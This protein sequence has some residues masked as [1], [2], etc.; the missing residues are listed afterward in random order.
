MSYSLSDDTHD[1]INSVV[2]E[3]MGGDGDISPDEESYEDV[4]SPRTIKQ[5]IEYESPYY[6]TGGNDEKD[7]EK[8]DIE[9][10]DI[11]NK[12]ASDSEKDDESEI[13]DITNIE[14]DDILRHIRLSIKNIF[15][16]LS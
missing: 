5:S 16:E 2:N 12:V 14:N 15:E 8:D 11:E 7:D 6:T 9:N 1:F 4:H 13:S 3:I 10:N